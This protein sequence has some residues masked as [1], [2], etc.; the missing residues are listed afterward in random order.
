MEAK[1]MLNAIKEVANNNAN[2]L[3]IKSEGNYPIL[4]EEPML[5]QPNGVTRFYGERDEEYFDWEELSDMEIEVVYEALAYN[6][7]L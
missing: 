1:E 5:I 2:D 7:Y 6:N 4:D 3:E